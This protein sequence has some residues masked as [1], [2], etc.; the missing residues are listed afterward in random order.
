MTGEVRNPSP[1]G[2]D[3]ADGDAL[4]AVPRVLR[5]VLADG[6]A[7]VEKASLDQDVDHHGRHGLGRRENH[8]RGV[9]RGGDLLRVGPVLRTVAPG[10]PDGT[11]EDH[12]ALPPY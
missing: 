8:E 11:V 10:V 4:L 3:V 1:M 5:D 9:R 12:A 7:E 2:Q 6:V